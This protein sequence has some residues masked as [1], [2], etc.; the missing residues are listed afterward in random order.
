[1]T[2]RLRVAELLEQRGW[3][4][5]RLAQETGLPR[6]T[7]YRLAKPGAVVHRIEGRNF[8][9]LCATFGVQPGDLLEYLPDKKRARAR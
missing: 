9:L 1:M 2:L 3:T 7:A 5:Y 8:E 4:A 6:E